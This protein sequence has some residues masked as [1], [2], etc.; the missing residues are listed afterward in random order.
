[1]PP[2]RVPASFGTY[3]QLSLRAADEIVAIRRDGSSVAAALASPI[4]VIVPSIAV[5]RNIQQAIARRQGRGVVGLTFHFPETLAFRIAAEAGV[6]RHVAD[7]A[8]RRLALTLA[9]RERGNAFGAGAASWLERSLRDLLDSGVD[10]TTV[11]RNLARHPDPQR[12]AAATAVW[13]RSLELL[14]A[15]GSNDPSELLRRAV[16]LLQRGAKIPQQI[17]FGFYD[18]TGLQEAMFRA[19]LDRE[20]VRSAWFPFDV[21]EELGVVPRHRFATRFFQNLGANQRFARAV[22]E[23]RRTATRAEVHPF[24]SPD[25]EFTAIAAAIANHIAQGAQPRTIGVVCRTLD[26]TDILRFRRCGEPFGVTFSTPLERSIAA[27]RLGRGLVAL[28]DVA[29]NGFRRDEVIELAYDGAGNMRAESARRLDLAT[30][31]L[32]I[33]GGRPLELQQLLERIEERDRQT[34]SAVDDYVRFV[35]RLEEI[36]ANI[37]PRATARAWSELLRTLLGFLPLQHTSDP[38]VVIAVEAIIERLASAPEGELER[39]D[40]IEMLEAAT[41]SDTP[42]ADAIWLG[43]VMGLRGRTFETLFVSGCEDDAFPQRRS[44][45]VLLPDGVRPYFGVRAVGDGEDEERM[46]FELTLAAAPEVHLTFSTADSGGKVRRPSRFIVQLCTT[47]FPDEATEIAREPVEFARKHYAALP[48]EKSR[49]AQRVEQ[50]IAGDERD[51][52]ALHARL[53]HAAAA[54]R[55]GG[56]DGYLEVNAPL[57]A[58]LIHRLS[59]ISPTRFERYG[60]CPQHFLL[61]SLLSVRELETPDESIEIDVRK[62][63]TLQHTIL[64]RF[65][66][67]VTPKEIATVDSWRAD[68]LPA[69]LRDKFQQAMDNAF[70]EFDERYPA[71]SSLIRRLERRRVRRKLIEWVAADLHELSRSG[72]VPRW[73]EFR[74][75]ELDDGEPA[76]A[77]AALLQIDPVTIRIRGSID[78]I[79]INE[80]EGRYR[81]IDYKEGTA[82]RHRKIGEHVDEGK[83]L[84]LAFYSFAWAQHTGVAPSSI[85]AHIRPLALPFARSEIFSFTWGDH[86][87]RFNETLALFVSSIMRGRFPAFPGDDAC[88]YCA[89]NLA[90]RTRHD[91]EEKLALAR[92]ASSRELLEE[93]AQRSGS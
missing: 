3:E 51:G 88:K 10:F 37:P 44:E 86:E 23:E 72:F 13:K 78:R 36:S 75:G 79:D 43:D 30:R 8:E 52:S 68:R 29:A 65:Y 57:S 92:F 81:I 11:E 26:A 25:E 61:S 27:T 84:Q 33:A 47:Q 64:E 80:A 87:A 19:L 45:D 6:S 20:L 17:L 63:G 42:P 41:L 14:H 38:D 22:G 74:F 48:S 7:S 54:G 46:L 49:V 35:T 77:P 91:D 21:D 67:S 39:D 5:A 85:E 89:V 34:W 82:G 15:R 59:L 71:T 90:C 16:E 73:F 50:F 60:E 69:V 66:R 4:E 56:Y 58:A 32:E 12:L 40:I 76:D 83:A 70:A 2:R 9:L 93:L 1:M 62:R 18:A 55:G 31:R 28:L 24:G 53:R